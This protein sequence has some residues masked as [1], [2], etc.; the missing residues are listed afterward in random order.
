M[1]S[2][3]CVKFK[4]GRSMKRKGLTLAEVLISILI[5]SIGV[6]GMFLIYPTLYQGVRVTSQKVRAWEAARQAI[7]EIKTYDFDTVLFPVSYD[8]NGGHPQPE[9]LFDATD[10]ATDPA[11]FPLDGS[12]V[13]Y[14]QQTKGDLG[15]G[16]V[17]NDDLVRVVVAVSFRA[18]NRVVGEDQDL[19]GILGGGEDTDGDGMLDSPVTLNTLIM[20]QE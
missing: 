3:K 5:V 20:Q 19:N 9:V 6:G 11:N 15:A 2:G 14:V 16:P 18:G 13:Y 7:E 8:V 12:A 10:H 1:Y 4:K 17:V